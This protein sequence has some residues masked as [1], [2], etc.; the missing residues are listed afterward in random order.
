MLPIIAVNESD[1]GA[2]RQ[3]YSICRLTTVTIRL[4]RLDVIAFGAHPSPAL[5]R[6]ACLL[7]PYL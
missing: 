1:L 6:G 4:R 7:G 3:S 2:A 5:T